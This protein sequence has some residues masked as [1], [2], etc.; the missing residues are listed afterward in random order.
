MSITINNKLQKYELDK[1]NK[2][3]TAIQK[4]TIRL[5][6]SGDPY[7]RIASRNLGGDTSKQ[8]AMMT[9]SPEKILSFAKIMR[10]KLRFDKSGKLYKVLEPEPES[11]SSDT[12]LASRNTDTDTSLASR[13]TGTDT[14][15]VRAKDIEDMDIEDPTDST[16]TKTTNSQGKKSAS[17]KNH[18][19]VTSS[20]LDLSIDKINKLIDYNNGKGRFSPIS[21]RK[22]RKLSSPV[23]LKRITRTTGQNQETNNSGD[24]ITEQKSPY[25]REQLMKYVDEKFSPYKPQTKRPYR[26]IHRQESKLK[27]QDTIK[28]LLHMVPSMF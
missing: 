17:K 2:I 10:A 20:I 14:S 28:T 16:T 11:V 8:L 3:G 12:S 5:T 24:G 9:T 22:I 15:S 26:F 18:R 25:S 13:N 23:K 27:P 19:L 4:G 1:V 21:L 6:N 7:P